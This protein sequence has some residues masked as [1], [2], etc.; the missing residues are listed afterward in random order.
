MKPLFI[1]T[2]LGGIIMSAQADHVILGKG[3][4]A[5]FNHYGNAEIQKNKDSLSV[6]FGGCNSDRSGA[7]QIFRDALAAPENDDSNALTITMKGDG[8]NGRFV[9]LCSDSSG[10]TWCWNGERWM[11]SAQISV[12]EDSWHKK[13]FPAKE[14]VQITPRPGKGEKSELNLQK[15]QNLQLAIGPNLTNPAK[16]LLSM[17]I[18]EI[19]M[20]KDPRPLRLEAG[21]KKTEK[22]KNNSIKKKPLAFR[23]VLNSFLRTGILLH[24]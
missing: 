24:G 16:K 9:I 3:K 1:L 23:S 8:S 14:F 2:L 11:D 18:S 10:R 4:F 12:L 15:I 7:L 5:H 21:E 19:A 22:E 6:R 13:V 17:E 20:E